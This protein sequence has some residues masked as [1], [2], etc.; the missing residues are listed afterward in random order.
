MSSIKIK[1][2]R[3]ETFPNATTLH[4]V[5]ELDA[6]SMDL[7]GQA[8][9][10][11][12]GVERPYVIF[13]LAEVTL[14]S[15]AAL[16]ILMG[17]RKRLVEKSGDLVLCSLNYDLRT[18]LNLLGA[19]KVFKIFQ[20]VRSAINAYRWEYERIGQRL[21]LE[22]PTELCF[23]PPVRQLVSRVAKQKGFSGRDAF[24][25]ETIIDEVCNN[26]IEH[27]ARGDGNHVDLNVTLDPKK[28]EIEVVNTSDPA[29]LDSLRELS[30]SIQ[31]TH[32]PGPDDRRGRGLA[33]IKMLSSEFKIDT[34][35]KGT[36]VH[37]TRLRG[38]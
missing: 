29:N 37:V 38:D 5:G 27:G 10:D 18:K 25:I 30:T 19:T 13:E 26:A 15:S 3:D 24:R 28:I 35:E 12:S 8:I 14:V 2:V 9:D 33:L 4:V 31:K 36:S 34:S 16:G 1:S 7:V 32:L 11:V 22:F 20:D 23:V 17:R 21:E 6:S